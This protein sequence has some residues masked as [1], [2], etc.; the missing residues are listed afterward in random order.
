MIRNI[1]SRV[2]GTAISTGRF[3]VGIPIGVARTVLS[4]VPFVG[5]KHGEDE[6]TPRSTG[7]TDAVSENVPQTSVEE[8]ATAEA[9]PA[10]A[11]PT[12][13]PRTAKKAGTPKAG[14]PGHVHDDGPEVVL[15][16][17]T[18]P[19]VIEPPIDVV[20]EALKAEQQEVE[21]PAEIVEDNPV[22]YST[23]SDDR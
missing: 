3:A 8:Q 19:E 23:S 16:I 22:V 15:S 10:T 17:D 21:P 11:P 4:H 2:T 20:G 1:A 6:S 5:G 14:E 7:P 18:P 13:T 9:K 12:K